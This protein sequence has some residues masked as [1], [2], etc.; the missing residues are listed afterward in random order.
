VTGRHRGLKQ[1]LLAGSRAPSRHR[2]AM[3]HQSYFCLLDVPS[4]CNT[5]QFFIVECGMHVFSGRCVY[6]TFG[7]HPNPLSYL[8][9]TFHFF[10][11]LHGWVSQ[12]RKITYSLT[13]SLIQLIWSPGNRSFRKSTTVCSV[14]MQLKMSQTYI[15]PV[16]MK[17]PGV[18]AFSM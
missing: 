6:S 13:H 15:Q 18:S 3:C 17:A 4:L 1:K 8:C 14:C 2:R 11:G 12:W 5:R 7:H 10:C 9:A 16:P